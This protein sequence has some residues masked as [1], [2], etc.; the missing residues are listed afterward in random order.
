MNRV[1]L[2]GD[3]HGEVKRLADIAN[4]IDNWTKDDLIIILGDFG[5]IWDRKTAK[6]KL[7][8]IA[9]LPFTVAFLDGNHENFPLI[10]EMEQIT[11]WNGGYIGMLSGGT[12]HLLRGEIY[13]INNKTIG[14]CGGANSI[15]KYWRT[16]GESWW[17]EEEIIE[18]DVNNFKNNLLI[19]NLE[20][21]KLNIMLSHDCPIEIL[22]T[23]R[24]FSGVNK[25]SSFSNSQKR[26]QEIYKMI[27]VDK[28]YFGHW[29][30]DLQLDDKFTCM[31]RNIKQII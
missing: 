6:L 24:A 19:K 8:Y 17:A 11:L 21:K 7:D 12:I 16:E 10:K 14:V 23:V 1:L 31:Y 3:I 22:P 26:L 25:M 30:F 13:N 28:W 29:H 9:E 18:N 20:N 4:K 15:D 27:N 5:C 2:M